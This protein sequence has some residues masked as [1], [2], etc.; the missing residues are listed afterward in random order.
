MN[1]KVLLTLTNTT[2][3]NKNH[4]LRKQSVILLFKSDFKAS[5]KIDTFL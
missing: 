1:E 5:H 2:A 3:S 4:A